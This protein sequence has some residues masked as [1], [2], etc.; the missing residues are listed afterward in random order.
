MSKDRLLLAYLL[1]EYTTSIECTNPF[2]QPESTL[3]FMN[4]K[5]LNILEEDLE[6]GEIILE[7]SRP[8]DT[9][10]ICRFNGEDITEYLE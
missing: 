1:Y 2:L 10:I 3:T 5:I 8:P 6:N 7:F 9:T 4:N